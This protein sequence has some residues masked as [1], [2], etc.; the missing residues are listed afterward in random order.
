MLQDS[1]KHKGLRKKLVDIVAGK[2]IT[3]PLVLAAMMAVPRHFF[4]DNAF[5]HFAYKDQAFPIGAEQTISQPYTVAF[6]SQLLALAGGEKVLEIGTGSGYQAS[7]LLEMG[8]KVF[9]IERHRSL[10]LRAKRLLGELG[11]QPKL[12]FGDGYKGLEAF[13]PFDRIIITAAAPH[14]PD[15]LKKQLKIGGSMVIPLGAGQSQQMQR[16]TK[17][18]E[19]DF[20]AEVYGEF[21]FVPM[22]QDKSFKS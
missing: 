22:L 18:S 6:Q 19:K 13:A 20:K 11:Y 5:I 12:F 1:Y 2:G 4:M 3:D 7:V 10:H 9:S 14:I 16:L 21:S 8:A 15:A 17:M